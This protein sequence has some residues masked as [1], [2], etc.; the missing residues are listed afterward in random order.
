MQ[1]KTLSDTKRAY[2]YYRDNPRDDLS[3]ADKKLAAQVARERLT[4]YDSFSWGTYFAGSQLREGTVDKYLELPGLKQVASSFPEGEVLDVADKAGA[5]LQ[6]G[7][8]LLKLGSGLARVGA[9]TYLSDPSLGLGG[10]HDMTSA[11]MFFDGRRG[12]TVSSG[13][14]AGSAILGSA[15][16]A[17]TVVEGVKEGKKEL[18]FSGLANGSMAIAQTLRFAGM[19]SPWGIALQGVAGV[20]AGVAYAGVQHHQLTKAVAEK[21]VKEQAYATLGFVGA[22]STA[23]G[24]SGISSV[25]SMAL[26]SLNVGGHCGVFLN[27][28]IANKVAQIGKWIVSKTGGATEKAIE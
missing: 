7:A 26:T 23:L 6:Q 17:M 4:G 13:L 14:L 22:A 2:R 24:L 10:L 9:G 27:K 15:S 3:K 28:K 19:Q 18:V 25:G 11:K 8:G 21:G 1:L 16:G 20:V 5:L 12:Q